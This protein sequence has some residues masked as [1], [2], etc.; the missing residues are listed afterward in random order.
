MS[1]ADIVAALDIASLPA[2]SIDTGNGLMLSP[3]RTGTDGF[4]IS[5]LK[6]A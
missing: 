4:F 6:R 5:V 1:G 2:A 3:G